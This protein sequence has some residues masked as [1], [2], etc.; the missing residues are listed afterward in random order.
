MKHYQLC[1]LL[2]FT[3]AGLVFNRLVFKIKDVYKL[4]LQTP[5]TIKE[6]AAQKVNRQNNEL[7][8]CHRSS[9]SSFNAMQFSR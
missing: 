3:S 8:K 4:G 5:Q 7:W 9:L 2:I 6:F 1:L